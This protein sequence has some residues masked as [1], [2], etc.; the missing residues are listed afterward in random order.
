MK[1]GI[2][3]KYMNGNV[4]MENSVDSNYSELKSFIVIVSFLLAIETQ[5]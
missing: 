5:Q 4:L 2:V 1:K 3:A